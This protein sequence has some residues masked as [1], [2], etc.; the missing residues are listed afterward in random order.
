MVRSAAATLALIFLPGL[1]Q[2]QEVHTVVG[3]ETLWGLAQQYYSD[4]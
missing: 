1:L 4:P 2:A 3:G